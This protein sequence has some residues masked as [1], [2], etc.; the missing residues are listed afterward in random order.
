MIEDLFR[1]TAGFYAPDAGVV[2]SL[3]AEILKVY[4]LRG[5]YYHTLSHLEHL[6]AEL[7]GVRN[8][9]VHWDTVVLA[10]CYHDFVY[11]AH[12]QDNEARSA[13]VARERLETLQYPAAETALCERLILATKGHGI[14]PE[15]DVN[16]FTDADLSVL[17]SA[18]EV[19][20]TYTGNIRK[21]YS[22]YPDFLYKPGRKKVLEHFLAMPRIFKTDIFYERYEGPARKNLRWELE[23]LRS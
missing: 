6:A 7:Q 12:Q 16:Y 11:A 14:D 19:Y 1:T 10:A 8:A 15:N 9:I 2:N 17:G 4:T 13:A 3:W 18:P 22:I 20:G 21:E 23:T 5:R